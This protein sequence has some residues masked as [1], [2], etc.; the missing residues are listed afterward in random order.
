MPMAAPSVPAMSVP[1]SVVRR[2]N[3]SSA[4]PV[5][6]LAVVS[7]T[8]IHISRIVAISRVVVGVCRVWVC[9]VVSVSR[10]VA[11][12][13]SH[14]HARETEVHGEMRISQR[15]RGQE[16]AAE[17]KG[18]RY[19][20]NPS[21]HGRPPVFKAVRSEMGATHQHSWLRCNRCPSGIA[22][23]LYVIHVS[24]SHCAI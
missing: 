1:T 20:Q 2:P 8:R 12:S 22:S 4:S 17:E 3:I 5:I 13:E 23:F 14:V 11:G 24:S 18:A 19:S 6:A 7:I 10:I 9:R 15:R 21:P 16:Q